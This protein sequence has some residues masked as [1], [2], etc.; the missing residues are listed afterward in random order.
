MNIIKLFLF[1][2]ISTLF[3]SCGSVDSSSFHGDA[4]SQITA[5]KGLVRDHTT[6]KLLADVNITI[7]ATNS[8]YIITDSSGSYSTSLVSLSD[9]VLDFNKSNYLPIQY[10]LQTTN[11]YA[12]ELETVYLVPAS[13][14]ILS[15]ASGFISSTSTLETLADVNV[16]IRKGINNQTGV[17]EASTSSLSDGSYSF[18]NI[19]VSTYTIEMSFENYVT[20]YETLYVVGGE[21]G[22]DQ[23]FSLSPEIFSIDGNNSISGTVKSATTGLGLEGVLLSLREGNNTKSGP[24]LAATTTTQTDGIDGFYSIVNIA[25]GDYTLEMRL[26]GYITGYGNLSVNAV[27]GGDNKHFVISPE[28]AADEEM[29]IVLTWGDSPR[30]MDSYLFVTKDDDSNETLYYASPKD[31]DDNK[32]YIP[33]YAK[34]DTDDVSGY[35]PETITINY[36]SSGKYIYFVKNYTSGE[37]NS[38]IAPEVAIQLIKSAQDIISIPITSTGSGLY[39][40]VLEI[41]NGVV[42]IKNTLGDDPR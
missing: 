4:D 28:L 39:W 30:D 13:I 26:D 18:A 10:I 32:S 22:S 31:P 23:N 3:V 21:S 14:D 33:D 7:S 9:Y 17:I 34:L 5:I 24:I 19:D 1:S 42:T 41:N 25:V 27:D 35:G 38:S 11:S 29:R 12:Q 40:E 15:S 8:S 37:F 20:G 6:G 36:F 16:S 2:F